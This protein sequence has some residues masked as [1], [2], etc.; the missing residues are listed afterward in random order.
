MKN[1][2][3]Q[4]CIWAKISTMSKETHG[5]GTTLQGSLGKWKQL[6]YDSYGIMGNVF[7]V[8]FTYVLFY[9]NKKMEVTEMNY[10]HK[11]LLLI[12]SCQVFSL[13]LPLSPSLVEQQVISIVQPSV[14]HICD[15]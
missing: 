4:F 12:G 5:Y 7:L 1:S 6:L 8:L 3:V 11:S 10:I 9:K 15:I 2:K 13:C 14:E